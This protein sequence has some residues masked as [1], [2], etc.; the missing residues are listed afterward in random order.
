MRES[1]QNVLRTM[2]A[3]VAVTIGGCSA[4]AP[5]TELCPVGQTCFPGDDP[6]G[7]GV[8]W[9]PA[10][11][12]SSGESGAEP[13]G[14]PP[15]EPSSGLPCEVRDALA[16][17]CGGCH[18]AVPAFGAPMPLTRYADLQVPA[19]TDPT[20]K[21]YEV[22]AERLVTDVKPMP[23]D[24]DMSDDERSIVLD[25]IADADCDDP[26]AWARTSNVG[27]H[28]KASGNVD[29]PFL[30]PAQGAEDLYQCFAFKAPFTEP[31]QAIAWAPII[32]DERVI[33]HWILYRTQQPQEEG[34]VFPCD[35]SLQ[36]QADFIAGW[37]PGGENVIMPPGVGLELGSPNDWYV[38][39]V[40][41]HN[42]AQY[43]DAADRSGV[44]FCTPETPEPQTAGVLTLGTT[45]LNIPAGADDH[46][47]VGNCGG[48][49]TLFWPELHILGASPHMHQLGRA[50]KT[51]LKRAGGVTETVIDKPF[52]F[53]S[54]GMY[55]N[56]QEIVVH[57][58]ETLQTT[59]TYDNPGSSPVG[60]GEGTGDEMCFNFVLVY[61]IDQL[62][63]RNCGIAF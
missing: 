55:F 41:Y 61:P 3:T 22:V 43:A 47:E 52:N 29:A 2:F 35:L 5:S 36:V 12:S 11:A 39:Q 63:N 10:D 7:G 38:M 51:E 6:G 25:W 9:D 23:P 31:T 16:A 45:S 15:S 42:E 49:L 32:D 34:G 24:G 1:M 28:G 33:H 20:R 30:V 48:L 46:T 56:D 4:G 59:C 19:H 57:A 17:A 44:A 40:H 50:M 13:P 27:S 37:A 8:T 58:G 60:F 14:E 62:A 21:V 53:E 18:G 26:G 54:Q